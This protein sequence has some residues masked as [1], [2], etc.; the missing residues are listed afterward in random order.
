MN[1][2]LS[3]SEGRVWGFHRILKVA[4]DLFLTQKQI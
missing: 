1:G 2:S 3:H 4:L